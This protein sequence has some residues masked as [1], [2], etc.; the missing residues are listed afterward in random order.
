MS[1]VK[2]ENRE[3]FKV[4]DISNDGVINKVN[5]SSE[6]I[7]IKTTQEKYKQNQSFIKT[8]EIKEDV[9]KE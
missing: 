1:V 7:K 6:S 3:V 5:D 2:R 8:N 4:K 9:H